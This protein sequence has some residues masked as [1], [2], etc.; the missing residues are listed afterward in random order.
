VTS[1]TRGRV[2]NHSAAMFSKCSDTSY[3]W[4]NTKQSSVS[5]ALLANAMCGNREHKNSVEGMTHTEESDFL[6]ECR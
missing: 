3:L 1:K 2:T 5:V 4:Q 6:N